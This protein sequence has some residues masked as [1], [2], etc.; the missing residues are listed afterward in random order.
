MG[1]GTRQV[2]GLPSKAWGKARSW[3]NLTKVLL[4]A[5]MINVT[6]SSSGTTHRG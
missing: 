2:A 3:D 6:L 1:E 4:I 5:R